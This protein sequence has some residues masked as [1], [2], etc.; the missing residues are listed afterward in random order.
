MPRSKS[1]SEVISEKKKIILPL[2]SWIIINRQEATQEKYFVGKINESA[3][4]ESLNKK[5]PTSYTDV[6]MTYQVFFS[7]LRFSKICKKQATTSLIM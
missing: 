1:Q 3:A 2:I 5:F 6:V 4:L 7:F